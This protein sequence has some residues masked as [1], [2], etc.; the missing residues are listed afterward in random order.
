MTVETPLRIPGDHPAFAGHF[1]GRPIVPG[2]VLL[3]EALHVIASATG[4]TLSACLINSVKFLSP[5]KPGEAAM[6]LHEVVDNGTI[7][8]EIVSGSRKIAA[9]SLT[10]EPKT[11]A[12]E[13]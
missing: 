2:V 9:G 4:I 13:R 11:P 6:I 8:F 3:D 12:P 10:P 7:R 5:L 1:P